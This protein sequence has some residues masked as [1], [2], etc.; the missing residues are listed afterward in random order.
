M[1][2][3]RRDEVGHDLTNEVETLLLRDGVAHT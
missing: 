1:G 2:G 3:V